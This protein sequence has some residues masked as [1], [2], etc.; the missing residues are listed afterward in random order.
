LTV[1]LTNTSAVPPPL[2]SQ[3]DNSY[4]KVLPENKRHFG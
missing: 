4:A 1:F 2:L 3:E